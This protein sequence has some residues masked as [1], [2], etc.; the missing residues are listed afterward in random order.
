MLEHF[1]E[2]SYNV[3]STRSRRSGSSSKF[4]G[5]SDPLSHFSSEGAANPVGS[6][7]V[8]KRRCRRPPPQA[9]PGGGQ[10]SSNLFEIIQ[11]I[12]DEDGHVVSSSVADLIL[13][14]VPPQVSVEVVLP[15]AEVSATVP[16][17]VIAEPFLT[18][19]ASQG[20]SAVVSPEVLYVIVQSF[21]PELPVVVSLVSAPLVFPIFGGSSSWASTA[22]TSS[23]SS[24]H[25][26][27]S[28]S[29]SAH[30]CPKMQFLD[31]DAQVE[32]SL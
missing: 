26:T 27:S 19:P 5:S 3:Q 30:A 8:P 18:H 15:Q 20:M 23:G 32:L 12:P 11:D 7:W 28:I 24:V 22:Q 1:F 25:A 2:R 13:P 16:S 14:E 31:I 6:G 29:V 4:L 17:L 21:T 9:P 10:S